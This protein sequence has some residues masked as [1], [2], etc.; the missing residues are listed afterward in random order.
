MKLQYYEE[1]VKYSSIQ[2]S[3]AKSDDDDNGEDERNF[4]NDAGGVQ[5]LNQPNVP[6]EENTKEVPCVPPSSLT[7][8]EMMLT[9]IVMIWIGILSVATLTPVIKDDIKVVIGVAVNINLIFFY[10]APLST[11]VDVLRTKNSSSIHFWTMVMNTINSF[12]WCVYSFAIQ[13]YYI[14]IPN[15]LGF[16]FGVMQM[17]L[18]TCFRQKE[19]IRAGDNAEQFLD[20]TGHSRGCTEENEII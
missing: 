7:S 19:D 11:I 3:S 17:I 9:Q 4:G 13:D 6:S 8:H 5:D 20:D 1:I 12:F 2:F 16:F 18:Y 14:L 10:A 15:G